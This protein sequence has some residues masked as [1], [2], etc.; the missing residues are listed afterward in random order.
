MLARVNLTLR[1]K[2]TADFYSVQLAKDDVAVQ[3]IE[4]G[5]NVELFIAA[6][7]VNDLQMKLVGLIKHDAFYSFFEVEGLFTADTPFIHGKI[8]NDGTLVY[9]TF[10]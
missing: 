8:K 5:F 10:E 4:Y 9:D 3:S 2:K 1:D 7:S 6:K